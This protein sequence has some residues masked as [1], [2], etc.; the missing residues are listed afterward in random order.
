MLIYHNECLQ[1][2]VSNSLPAGPISPSISKISVSENSKELLNLSVAVISENA[3]IID[4][5]DVVAEHIKIQHGGD[6]HIL[7]LVILSNS[8]GT[9]KTNF[10]SCIPLEFNS[11]IKY[12]SGLNNCP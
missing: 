4:T 10:F 1:L 11:P 12:N 8:L 9:S 2:C 6:L 3:N 7:S 5:I